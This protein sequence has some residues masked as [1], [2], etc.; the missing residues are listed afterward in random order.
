MCGRE[1]HT[2]IFSN[3]LTQSLPVPF[4]ITFDD[5]AD[6]FLFGEV[7]VISSRIIEEGEEE[8]EEEARAL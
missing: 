4:V 3:S 5:V 2:S 1:K 7:G 8:G 6:L